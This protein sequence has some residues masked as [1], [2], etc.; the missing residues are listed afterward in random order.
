MSLWA[1]YY[2][3]SVQNSS[4]CIDGLIFRSVGSAGGF[5][6][7]SHL[8]GEA[9]GLV[10]LRHASR[11][12]AISQQTNSVTRRIGIISACGAVVIACRTDGSGTNAH[13]HPTADIG[14]ASNAAMIDAACMDAAYAATATATASR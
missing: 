1:S 3:K 8:A 13:G 6:S 9:T 14:S 5:A 7:E 10:H 12:L 11:N 4:L 2:L